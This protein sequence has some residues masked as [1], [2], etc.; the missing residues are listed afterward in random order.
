MSAQALRD[1][2]KAIA[3]RRFEP[4][5]YFHGDD[6][7][8]KE[9]AVRELVQGAV[10]PTT[11]D[12]NFD[13]L[14]GA[15]VSEERL[16]SALNTPPMMA[17]RRVVILRDV[18]ALKK[19]VR[20]VLER[21][22]RHPARDTVLALHASAG[23]PGTTKAEK[24]LDALLKRDAAAI[25]FPTLG[26]AD[27]QAWLAHHAREVHGATLTPEAAALLH[28]HVGNDSAQLASELDKLAS[29]TQSDTIDEQAVRDVVGVRQ[30]ASM[31]DLLDRVA[32]RNA[33]AALALIEPVMALPK[34]GLVPIIMALTVQTL[35]LGWGRQ[36]RDRGMPPQRMVSDY[37]TL[38]KETGA[39]PMRPWGDA[40]KCWADNIARWDAASVERG[41]AALLA[42]DRAVKDTRISSEEQLLASLVL[43]LC[44]APRAAA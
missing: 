15:E 40:T 6:E 2:R 11:R 39:F 12:F 14:R 34:S 24:D 31:S 43:T 28:E 35:A 37:F 44:T 5:Y 20:V 16:E 41:L 19:D 18:S 4:A 25:A 7:Y 38:L 27:A 33:P 1:L 21:Y 10:D 32:E 3:H 22:L 30:G 9:A 8:R 29:Y 36:A 13:L 42:A 17:D 26:D 23:F